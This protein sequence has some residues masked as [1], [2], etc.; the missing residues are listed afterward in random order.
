MTS[1]HDGN[2][3]RFVKSW[4]RTDGGRNPGGKDYGEG[5]YAFSATAMDEIARI[6]YA[7]NLQPWDKSTTVY[8]YIN[9]SYGKTVV[10][11]SHGCRFSA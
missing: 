9:H 1:C 10:D 7:E 5:S 4:H 6:Y 3:R 8:T 2:K 11:L